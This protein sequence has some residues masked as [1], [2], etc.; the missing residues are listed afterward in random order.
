[1]EYFH[2]EVYSIM[3]SVREHQAPAHWLYPV[4]VHIEVKQ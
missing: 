1:M 2:N 4:I 3:L